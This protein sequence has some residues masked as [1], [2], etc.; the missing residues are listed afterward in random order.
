MIVEHAAPRLVWAGIGCRFSVAL[1]PLTGHS[2][3]CILGSLYKMHIT[4]VG[5]PPFAALHLSRT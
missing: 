5:A 3:L 1:G 2:H 4:S